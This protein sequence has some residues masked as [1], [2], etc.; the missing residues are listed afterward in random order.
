MDDLPLTEMIAAV[1]ISVQMV[2]GNT[3]ALAK[4]LGIA[5]PGADRLQKN[6]SGG[7]ERLEA[8]IVAK[9]LT[10]VTLMLVEDEPSD[11]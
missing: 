2:D 11:V 5:T 7:M 9:A 3:A 4:T 10:L 1:Q 6:L 8:L